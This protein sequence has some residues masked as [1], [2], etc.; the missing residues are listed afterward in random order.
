[1]TDC[2]TPSRTTRA[3]VSSLRPAKAVVSIGSP[4]QKYNRSGRGTGVGPT[5]RTTGGSA[6]VV[7]GAADHPAR[8]ENV[9]PDRDRVVGV[10]AR[11]A[12]DDPAAL[13]DLAIMNGRSRKP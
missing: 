10:V 11:A 2:L 8:A 9:P 3:A 12:G 13:P 4:N 7:A 5:P 6:D 1:M